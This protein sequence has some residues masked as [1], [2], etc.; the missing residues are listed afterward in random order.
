MINTVM[1]AISV[2]MCDILFPATGLSPNVLFQ[3]K[4]PHFK[5]STGVIRKKGPS[6]KGGFCVCACGSFLSQQDIPETGTKCNDTHGH[7]GPLFPDI[8]SAQHAQNI[9][10]TN[11]ACPRSQ[12]A[13]VPHKIHTTQPH[14]TLT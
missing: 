9:D 1:V 7:R 12:R 6:V 2:H 3:S 8:S 13:A 14:A 5:E 4:Y 10:S 11:F